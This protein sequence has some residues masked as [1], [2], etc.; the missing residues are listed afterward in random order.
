MRS[1]TYDLFVK[2]ELRGKC[3][4]WKPRIITNVSPLEVCIIGPWL[5]SVDVCIRK[6]ATFGH[7]KFLSPSGISEWYTK[8]HD[9]DMIVGDFS[10][11]DH[12]IDD[13]LLQ[14]ER[15]LFQFFPI[16][17][18]LTS[19]I[20][21][22]SS[23][24]CAM[25][26]NWQTIVAKFQVHGGLRQSGSAQ[27]SIGNNHIAVMIHC[28]VVIESF[29]RYRHL[30]QDWYLTDPRVRNCLFADLLN[31]G[32]NA[33]IHSWLCPIDLSIYT[34]LGLKFELDPEFC[35]ALPL[36]DGSAY[37][38]VRKPSEFLVRFGFNNHYC[39]D[40]RARELLKAVCIGYSHL[41]DRI[42]VYWSLVTNA[43]RL[44]EHERDIKAELPSYT[45]N[46]WLS[47][48]GEHAV[49][50]KLQGPTDLMRVSF[51]D[52][53]GLSVRNQK[54]L[55]SRFEMMKSPFELISTPWLDDFLVT[56]CGYGP[57][58]FFDISVQNVE[59]ACCI[60]EEEIK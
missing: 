26:K 28:F 32:D 59:S 25:K 12:S 52:A 5:H 36:F 7:G 22:S 11:F 58:G 2:V 60:Q 51:Q 3:P 6:A 1:H 30:P 13:D 54:L 17:K 34:E 47:N 9:P 16:P 29:R 42:P 19:F 14:I 33:M 56:A 31:C 37:I 21:S 45:L 4:K 57:G 23:S 50:K 20:Y 39:N 41:V 15:D 40:K 24:W 8:H 18:W 10:S 44:V 35:Q 49:F 48:L 38:F 55:E 27:T 53:F 43:Y 46:L